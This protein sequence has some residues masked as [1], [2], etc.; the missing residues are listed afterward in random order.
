M[1]PQPQPQLMLPRVAHS[2]LLQQQQD[3]TRVC[4][5][6]ASAPGCA[7]RHF[8]LQ[9]C[10]CCWLRSGD[11]ARL[12]RLPWSACVCFVGCRVLPTVCSVTMRECLCVSAQVVCCLNLSIAAAAA[13]LRQ[14]C[15]GQTRCCMQLQKWWLLHSAEAERVM[16]G[17]GVSSVCAGVDCVCMQESLS[18]RKLDACVCVCV[19]WAFPLSVWTMTLEARILL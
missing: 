14:H 18:N 6:W 17:K 9:V 5:C 4:G 8:L 7:R 1:S 11:A 12:V 3:L 10:C 13:Q 16:C 2:H 19:A 15:L